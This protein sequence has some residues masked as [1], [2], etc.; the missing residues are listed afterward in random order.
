M[1]LYLNTFIT[2]RSIGPGKFAASSH[3]ELAD[4]AWHYSLLLRVTAACPWIFITRVS[5]LQG[6]LCLST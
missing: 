2:S 6:S 5:T 4:N 1:I 3:R